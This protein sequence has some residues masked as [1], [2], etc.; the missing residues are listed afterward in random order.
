MSD[1]LT[2]Y[3]KVSQMSGEEFRNEY[4]CSKS[5]IETYLREKVKQQILAE[6]N[7]TTK[8]GP[9]KKETKNASSEESK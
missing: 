6:E 1:F 3:A 2:E 7:K 5:Q 9:K 4:G 8:P